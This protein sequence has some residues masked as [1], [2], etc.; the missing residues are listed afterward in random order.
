VEGAIWVSLSSS[1]LSGGT[2]VSG[3]TSLCLVQFV[4][5]LGVT[6]ATTAIPAILRGVDAPDSAAGLVA[7]AYAM[8]FGG[9][10][11]LGARLADRIGHRRVLLAGIVA[12]AMV[13]VVGAT[14]KDIVQVIAA[15]GLQGAAAAVSVPSALRLLLHAAPEEPRRRTALA[16]WSGAGAAA[17]AL[18][19]VVGGALAELLDWRAVFWVNAP[20]GVLLVIGV[21]AVVPT[22]PAEDHADALDVPGALLLIAA[23]MAMVAGSSLV[24]SSTTRWVGVAVVLA[25][26]A[27]GV[28]F[29]VRQRT[30]ASPL[31]P[32]AAFASANLR[33]GTVVSFVNTATTSSAGVLASLLVQDRL[34]AS[35]VQAGLLLVPFSLAVIAGSTLSRPLTARVATRHAAAI[36]LAG[37][38][39][40]NVVFAA[41]FGSRWGIVAG[42]AV[43]GAGL[44]LASVAAT[45]IGTQ[46]PESITGSASGILNTGA[47][48]GTALG[49][50]ALVAVASFGG[51]GPLDPT[52]LAWGIAAV[53][54]GLTALLVLRTRP[55]QPA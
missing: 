28:G 51:L 55:D 48:L 49:V 5:V 9:L 45:S 34:G 20:V 54:A 44:G 35:P 10:L 4:D 26:V 52:A 1:R 21:L 30:A 27:V 42:A 16:A 15:R 31:I 39:L 3:P 41:T 47:Q 18:G 19:F 11:V 23:V 12:F 53:A 6:S 7:T 14:A 37:I 50:A 2:S 32:L 24:E 38:A 40:G 29:V 25:G 36:G 8:F 43:A 13:S 22:L 46:V 33:T 17:G